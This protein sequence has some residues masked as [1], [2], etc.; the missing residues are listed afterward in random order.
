MQFFLLL[1]FY[2]WLLS[3]FY[4]DGS[5]RPCCVS[6][7]FNFQTVGQTAVDRLL[8]QAFGNVLVSIGGT[9]A[10]IALWKPHVALAG[11]EI[12]NIVIH[13]KKQNIQV[14]NLP[15]VKYR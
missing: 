7:K 13:P 2:P 9:E 10:L 8:D 11:G 14:K 1:S 6:L 3:N 5:K 12:E 15:T 4:Q